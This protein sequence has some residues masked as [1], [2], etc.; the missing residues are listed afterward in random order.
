[1]IL[2]D[3]NIPSDQAEQLRARRLHF[4]RVGYEVGRP[5]WDDQQEIL[6]YLHRSKN[7]TVITR[8]LG[9]FHRR[10]C[11]PNYCIVVVAGPVLQT[12]LYA[13]RLLRQESF[14]TN[15]LRRNKVIRL[16]PKNIRWWEFGGSHPQSVSWDPR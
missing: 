8:D 15:A 5:E 3:H 1:M 13:H 4:R 12:A 7:T 2:L 10:F 9:F 16:L 14:R 6:P 11:H